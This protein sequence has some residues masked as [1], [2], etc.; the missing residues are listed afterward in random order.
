LDRFC[1]IAQAQARSTQKAPE[2][3]PI[4][5]YFAV[6]LSQ[7]PGVAVKDRIFKYLQ[8]AGSGV[9][10]DQI[11]SAVFKIHAP[12]PHSSNI[13][14][15][16]LLSRDPR[17]GFTQ[18]LWYLNSSN[19]SQ[20][21]FSKVSVL[22]LQCPDRSGTLRSLR[23]AIRRADGSIREFTASAAADIIG[24]IRAEIEGHVL[25][26]WSSRELRLWNGLLRSK[27]L[28]I[29]QGNTLYLRSLAAR[30]LERKPSRLEP[31]D[32]ASG[33]GISPADEERP[34]EIAQYLYACWL[35]VLNCVPAEFRQT[36]DSLREWADGLATTVD[37]SR[38]SFGPGFLQQ[39]PGESGIYIMKDREG[40]VLY[41]G[42]SRNLKRRVSSYFSPRALGQPKI[43]RIHERLYSIEVEQTGNEVEA[44]LLEMRLI[45][46]FRPAVNLQTEIHAR[47][48]NR[49]EGRNLLLFVAD[50]ESRGV[51]IYFFR[52]GIFAGKQAAPMRHPPSKRLREKIRSL[53]FNQGRGRKRRGETWEK[54][55]VSRW[56]TA[57]QRRLNCL[58]VDEA[59][60]FEAVLDLLRNYLCDPERL[61]HKVYYR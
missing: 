56:L 50:A 22:F 6:P 34:P 37:F 3:S 1:A 33:L 13:I 15:A 9:A 51:R 2:I 42:K 58:D 39:L 25:V 8:E 5:I 60:N 32:I 38:F 48:A 44:L 7:N 47:R 46:R 40:T 36:P 20:S 53:Y 45:K 14:L 49:H 29:W 59:K 26:V 57:N 55:I 19:S 10:A 27:G 28:E 18:G 41:V 4:A 43:A 23:G 35:L 21:D 52:N 54:E 31:E 17:F 12:D 30:A 16:G 11:L 61:M 24:R